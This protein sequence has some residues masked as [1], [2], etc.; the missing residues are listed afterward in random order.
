MLHWTAHVPHFA[1]HTPVCNTTNFDV[2]QNIYTCDAITYFELWIDYLSRGPQ[3]FLALYSF[4][5]TIIP[6]GKGEE[7][8][9]KSTITLTFWPHKGEMK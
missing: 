8:L 2:R 5:V 9:Q 4:Y 6:G 1:R 3:N 7:I